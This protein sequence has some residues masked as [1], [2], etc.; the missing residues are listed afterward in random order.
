[1]SPLLQEQMMVLTIAISIS[2]ILG[3]WFAINK[4]FK[5][6]QKRVK[7]WIETWE[8]FMVDWAG[9]EA[10]EG[11]DAIPGVMERLNNIDGELK[12]NGGS[13]LKDAVDRIHDRLDEG[14]KHFAKM[15]KKI[16]QIEKKL[17]IVSDETPKRTS[18]RKAS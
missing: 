10:R 9:E 8:N 17:E 12:R 3:A 4:L 5:P 2:T 15:D 1:M 11:R 14:N 6:L 16:L 7:F 18:R 13:S